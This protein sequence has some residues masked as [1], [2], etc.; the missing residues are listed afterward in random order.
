MKEQLSAPSISW[1]SI[2]KKLHRSPGQCQSKWK[3]LQYKP[4]GHFTTEEDALILRTVEN[5]KHAKGKGLW[6]LLGTQL[7]RDHRIVRSR[8]RALLVPESEHKKKKAIIRWN[9]EMVSMYI[10][11]VLTAFACRM[12][13]YKCCNFASFSQRMLP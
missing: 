2:A 12:L 10:L 11:L 9:D 13:D 4:Q 3:T 5:W 1:V 7:Q 6:T 8:Y